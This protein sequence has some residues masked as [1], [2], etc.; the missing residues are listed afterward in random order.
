MKKF[1]RNQK[2]INLISLTITVVVILIITNIVIYNVKDN[3]KT[4]RIKALQTDISNLR[5][6]I[7][8]YYSQYGKIPANTE[9][10]NTSGIDVISSAVDTGKFYVIDLSAL[11]NLTL[12]YGTDY[13]KIKSG[14]VTDVNTLSDLYIINDDSHNIF[15]VDGVTLDNQTFY[16]DYTTKD[17]DT[18]AVDLKYIDG[19]KIP[20]GFYYV[21][22]TKDT[23]L[24]ISDA[25][26][27]DLDN[28]KGGNQFVWIPVENKKDYERNT[29]YS[30]TYVAENAT[31]DTNYLPYGIDD[32]EKA[33]IDAGGF[34]VS[35]FEVGI[36]SS[37][38][39]VSKK[40]M[41]VDSYVT[42]ERAKTRAKSIV[43]T[44]SAKSALC[45]GTQWDLVMKFVDG[46]EGYLVNDPISDRHNPSGIDKTGANEKDKVCNIY[47]L[48]GN[49]FEYVADKSTVQPEYEP[50][51][52]RGGSYDN[53]IQAS[54]YTSCNGKEDS[55]IAFRAVLYVIPV[56]SWSK[57]YDQ[58]GIYKDKNDDTATIPAGFQ[59]SLVG[60]QNKITNG[61]VVRGPDES[62]F[63]WVPVDDINDMAQ[64][65]TAGGDC[66]LILSDG[67]ELM[68]TTHNSTEI[69]GK[70]YATETGENFG[71]VN[72]TYNADS[73][74]REPAY[75]TNSS[76]ADASSYNAIEL[77]LSNMQDEYRNMAA[78]VAKY[79]GFY[80]GRYETSLSDATESSA[81]VNEK[82][83][84]KQGVIP[85]SV[86]N[87]ATYRWYGLYSKQKEYTGKNGSVESSMIWGSQYDA[88]L[89]WAK[90][91]ADKDKITNTS[92]GNHSGSV[93]TTG[94]SNYPNDSINNIR[95]LGG[96]LIEWTLEA[97]DTSY[98]VYRGGAYNGTYSPSYRNYNYPHL[99][100]SRIGSRVTLYIK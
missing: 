84:S 6:K 82:A 18:E 3:L 51:I 9:Y 16:T 20:D 97:Y 37:V 79:G 99:T 28:S 47:D 71:T 81:G 2:G 38:G 83:Q 14:E 88:M 53:T 46:K 36:E 72:T 8:T 32:E 63:V 5:D 19:V 44:D 42:Q 13:E 33:V 27:D 90:N 74:L 17:V 11:D 59:V 10:T 100:G 31:S 58:T 95:D 93:T 85:T 80:V 78:K 52:K 86:Y 48:E 35:R 56:E 65:S 60:S 76:Y 49:V 75:L 43:N 25:K 64:C 98:R 50:C 73:G 7:S 57:S 15:Y 69:V 29:N 68:C 55:S 24:V 23:G 26:D 54:T 87:S 1:F 91:G 66:N 92:L 61:L 96:N 94:N 41:T 12:N 22:G 40:G 62:E 34:F 70:L 67:D 39:P 30:N 21:G 45:S 77:T 4:Q 89:N